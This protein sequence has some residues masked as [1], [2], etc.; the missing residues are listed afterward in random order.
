MASDN[1]YEYISLISKWNLFEII[2]V[3]R[4]PKWYL[5]KELDCILWGWWNKVE[6]K[7]QS[8][9][10]D[11]TTKTEKEKRRNREKFWPRKNEEESD[12]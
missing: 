12:T 1:E 6:Q 4:I 8:H 2:Y 11:W 7:N 5:L 3:L 10:A 9:L